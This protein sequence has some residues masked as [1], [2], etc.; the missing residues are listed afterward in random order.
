MYSKID[1]EEFTSYALGLY[2]G[3]GLLG[4]RPEPKRRY[5][6]SKHE[7]RRIV[8]LAN[9]IRAGHVSTKRVEAREE[10]IVDIWSTSSTNTKADVGH[11]PFARR[12][13][14]EHSLSYNPPM[15]YIEGER[16]KFDTLREVPAY[17]AYMSEIYERLVNMVVVPRKKEITAP[18][19]DPNS[20]LPDL[21]DPET[22]E[23]YPNTYAFSYTRHN[24]PITCLSI[25]PS[26]KYLAV[27]TQDGCVFIFDVF[28]T[29]CLQ[30]WFLGTD[31]LKSS[32]A[33]GIDANPVMKNMNKSSNNAGAL[34]YEAEIDRTIRSI[35]WNP[36]GGVCILAAGKIGRAHV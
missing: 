15:E 35:A 25:D 10:P 22:L 20:L 17:R 1:D 28:T 12:A 26:G 23:P 19:I 7:H 29:R 36:H 34:D 16:E 21:P 8:R 18:S 6:P 9:A 14:P 5:V 31:I 2:K 32:S 24:Y 33:M 4:V 13:L 27:G 11:I 3:D 30:R